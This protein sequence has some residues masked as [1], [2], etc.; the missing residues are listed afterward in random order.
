M[1]EEA[2]ALYERKGS[3]VAAERTRALLEELARTLPLA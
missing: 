3:V 2:F 1:L